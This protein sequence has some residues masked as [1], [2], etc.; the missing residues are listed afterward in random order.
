MGSGFGTAAFCGDVAMVKSPFGGNSVET[1]V[2]YK[3]L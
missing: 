3:A 2:Q 1:L